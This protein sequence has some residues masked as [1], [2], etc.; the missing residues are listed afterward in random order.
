VGGGQDLGEQMLVL[1]LCLMLSC[2]DFWETMGF[3]VH[4]GASVA[5]GN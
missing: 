1:L 2:P 4:R 5:L 3:L